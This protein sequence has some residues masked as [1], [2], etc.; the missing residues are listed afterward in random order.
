MS[1]VNIIEENETG[2]SDWKPPPRFLF[3]IAVL[4]C[5]SD[6]DTL[7]YLMIALCDF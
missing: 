3:L 5:R 1:N 7:S 6:K 4:V 2:D